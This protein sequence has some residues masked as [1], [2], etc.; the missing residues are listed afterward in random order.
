MKRILI[1]SGSPR[2][3]GNTAAIVNSLIEKL[4]GVAKPQVL[5]IKDLDIHSCIGCGSCQKVSGEVGCVYKDDFDMVY[6]EMMATDLILY[7]TP[8]YVWGFTSIMQK[9]MERQCAFVKWSVDGAPERLLKGMKVMLLATSGGAIETNIDLLSEIYRREV[10]YNRM[11]DT[12]IYTVGDCTTPDTIADKAS[13][14]SE[15]MYQRILSA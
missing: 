12:G 7:T 6:Q 5:H 9:L 11:L 1:L 14:T 3:K 2:K 13:V 10:N 15:A 4:Q 8:V